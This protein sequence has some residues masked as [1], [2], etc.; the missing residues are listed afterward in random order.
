MFINPIPSSYLT[1]KFGYRTHPVTGKKNSFH[2][3]VDLARQPNSNVEILAAADG[4]VI[5]VGTLGTY[6]KVVMIKHSI[7]GKR[8]DTNYAHLKSYSVKVGQKVKQGQQIGVM[9]NT[10]SSTAPHLH[11]EIHNGPWLS[12]QPNAVD[13]ARYIKFYTKGELAEMEK[14]I[15]ELEKTVKKLVSNQAN[16][17]TV[18][19]T[20]GKTIE[21]LTKGPTYF[22]DAAPSEWAEEEVACAKALGITDGTY[23]KRQGTREET[24]TMQV[25]TLNQVINGNSSLLISELAKLSYNK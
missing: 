20:Q 5:R 13:P 18:I 9:G 14:R 12:K 3:G 24:I 6:G 2:Q 25:R 15:K 21:L 22:K 23:L 8:M 4:E 10:G 19:E 17:A 7:N 16:Q 11:F 1:S